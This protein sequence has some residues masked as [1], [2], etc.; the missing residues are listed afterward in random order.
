MQAWDHYAYTNNNPLRY[1]DPTGH[2]ACYGDNY[3]DGPQCAQEGS[4]SKWYYDNWKYQDKVEK[5]LKK[6]V[7]NTLIGVL[8]N[9]TIALDHL[10]TIISFGEAGIS[11]FAIGGSLLLS[12]AE[13]EL[14]PELIGGALMIDTFL[15]GPLNPIGD[16]QNMLGGVSFATTAATDL[17]SGNTSLSGGYVGKDTVVAG[18]NAL[19]GLIPESNSDL[20]VNASQSKYDMDRLNGVKPGGSIKFTDV[21]GLVKQTL[22][23][24]SPF[25]DVAN[26]LIQ[27]QQF[28]TAPHNP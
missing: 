13:P 8:T 15:A 24:D 27:W 25:Q 3:D 22:W 2:I 9:T 19:L 20:I 28:L 18:R 14:A 10:S 26:K 23:N 5:E 6:K 7:K 11:D 16:F 12:A 21:G 17:L 1:T 4:P